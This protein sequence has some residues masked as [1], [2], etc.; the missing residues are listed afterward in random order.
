MMGW[1]SGIRRIAARKFDENAL[2][3]HREES[4]TTLSSVSEQR[5]GMSETRR[6]NET[7]RV[8]FLQ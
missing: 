1:V 6:G 3:F 7:G 8:H 5:E 2:H 4:V